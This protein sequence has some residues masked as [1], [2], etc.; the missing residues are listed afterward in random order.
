[1]VLDLVIK[2]TVMMAAAYAITMTASIIVRTLLILRG[3]NGEVPGAH[4][5][6]LGIMWSIFIG[7][8]WIY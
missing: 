6:I 4:F 1:M 7:Y 3:G 2:L 8:I 5:F